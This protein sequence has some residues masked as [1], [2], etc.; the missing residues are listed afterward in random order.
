MSTT[1]VVEH[2]PDRFADRLPEPDRRDLAEFRDAGEWGELIDLLV[3]SLSAS[4]APVTAAERE[5]LRRLMKGMSMPTNTLQK[6][7]LAA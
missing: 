3:A 4:R 7:R 5:E 2:L 1:E 6:L